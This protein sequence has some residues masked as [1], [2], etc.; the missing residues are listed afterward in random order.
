MLGAI[1]TPLLDLGGPSFVPA[2]QPLGFILQAGKK[3]LR[4]LRSLRT[5]QSKCNIQGFQNSSRHALMLSRKLAA[6]QHVWPSRRRMRIL[7]TGA[8]SPVA[9]ELTRQ[10]SRAGHQV[11]LAD[12][13]AF[14]LAGF[15][16]HAASYR[17]VP[18]PRQETAAFHHRM[19]ELADEH[20]LVLPTCEEVLWV[21]LGAQPEGAYKAFCP[22]FD[23]LKCLHNKWTFSQLAENL[24]LPVP[25][26]WL[27]ENREAALQVWRDHRPVVLKPV[28]SRFATHT[29][30]NPTREEQLPQV[31]EPWVA[32]EFWRGR[33]FCSFSIAHRG[34]L[35][36]H[37]VYQPV[38]RLSDGAG[39]TI[40]SVAHQTIDEWV[41]TFLGRLQLTG[42][43]AFDF[44]ENAQGDIAALECNPRTTSGVHLFAPSDGLAEAYFGLGQGC[45]TPPAGRL[46]M[47]TFASLVADPWRTLRLRAKPIVCSLS[48]P[49]PAFGQALSFLEFLWRA[50]GLRRAGQ[51]DSIG[52]GLLEATTMDIAWDEC[53]S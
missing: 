13:V 3:M 47:L 2:L 21:A 39:V 45:R 10:F 35:S 31:T 1:E 9:L 18:R 43:F 4:Q 27:T 6:T 42:Q 32:Q 37:V 15:S 19:G 29:L 34:E 24:G 52:R 28:Y 46:A 5:V 41:R 25:R 14:P 51:T 53:A 50:W 36:A 48:D 8:R 23:T 40:R 17:R 38:L 26:T 30:I 22:D 12:S 20:D 33:H 7:L 16:R 44:I 49:G 11:T